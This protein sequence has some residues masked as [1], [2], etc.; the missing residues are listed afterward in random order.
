MNQIYGFYHIG[1]I[2]C[3][4]QIYQEH[5][6]L[7]MSSGL[8]K[9]TNKI[10]VGTCGEKP[11]FELWSKAEWVVHNKELAD[12]EVETIK[13]IYEFSQTHKESKI[14]YLHTKG[15]SIILNTKTDHH[16][17]NTKEVVENVKSWRDY[18]NYF[19]IKKHKNCIKSLDEF[20]IC[21]VEWRWKRKPHF[22]GNFWWANSNYIANLQNIL[23]S[24]E[25]GYCGRYAAETG[26]LAN[27]PKLPKVKSFFNFNKDLYWNCI[28]P[29]N[30]IQIKLQ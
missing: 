15:A 23:T 21:G 14:W 27:S 25:P 20:D 10:F 16:G 2:G 9:E 30:Y 13:K 5:Q 29:K 11:T 17:D 4:K 18:M 12:G 7:L 24:K 26:F 22:A 1:N 28:K 3:W 6:S 8:Y 19:V